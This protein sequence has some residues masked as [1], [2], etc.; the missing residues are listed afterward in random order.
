[1]KYLFLKWNLKKN[2]LKT[3]IMLVYLKLRHL[4]LTGKINCKSAKNKKQKISH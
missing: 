4:K 2:V 3:W 1:M